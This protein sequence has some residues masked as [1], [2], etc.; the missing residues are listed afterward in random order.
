MAEARG[1][2]AALDRSQPV[3]PIDIPRFPVEEGAILAFARA[4]GDPN[5]IYHDR[6][7][8]AKSEFGGIIAPPT[9]VE[10][11]QHFNPASTVRPRVGERWWG[12]ARE[13]ASGKDP[14]GDSGG[15]HLHGSTEFTY[16][17]VLRPGMVLSA[18]T[19]AG[20]SWMKEGKRS[21]SILF[22]QQ[23]TEYRDQKDEL[24]VTAKLVCASTERKVDQSAVQLDTAPVREWRKPDFPAAYPVR[25]PRASELKPGTSF[26]ERIIED[27]T[28]AQIILYAGASG[29]FSPQHVD[30]VY[31]T[32]VAGYPTVF[33]H[34]MLTMGMTARALTDWFGD[35]RLVRLN[36]AFRSQVWP[37]DSLTAR[38][39]VRGIR[40]EAGEPLVDVDVVTTN[41]AG[42]TVLIG[43]ATARVDR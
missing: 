3:Y 15:T 20:E 17:G 29:D 22:R 40:T 37:G 42:A 10:A 16:H 7:Y 32:K 35:G 43:D 1:A 9:F 14:F 39:I 36:L 27:L 34:G 21:G 13:P 19:R 18:K 12:S 33:A 8:A 30:E 2:L 4:V 24:L 25:R 31:N 11:G 28:R 26:A 6:A 38:A 41:Q 23:L 5:P